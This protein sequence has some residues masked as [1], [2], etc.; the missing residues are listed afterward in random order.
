M[1]YVGLIALVS[2]MVAGVTAAQEGGAS[3]PAALDYAFYKAH[4]EPLFLVKRP[5]RMA[6]V[7]CHERG[8]GGLKLQELTNGAWAE[9]ASRKN[10]AAVSAWVAPGKP[11]TSRLLQHPLDP[12]DG[13]DPFH[14]GGKHW[15]AQDP[16]YRTL[17]SWVKGEIGPLTRTAARVIQ[18]NSAGDSAHV[19]DPATQKVIGEIYDVPIAHGV[20]GAPDGSKL[21]I[22][23]EA[24]HTLDVVDARSLSV[25]ARVPLSGRP[26]NVYTSKDGGKVY[27]GIR[28]APGALDVID[29]RTLSRAK[30]VAV[31]G[32]VH[33]VY[34]TPD[35]KYAVAGSIAGKSISIVDTATDQL[36]RSFTLSNGV[37]PIAFDTKPDGSTN[38]IFAQLSDFHGF[39]AVD[40]ATGKELARIEHP[41]IPGVHAHRDG[42][43]GAPAHGLVVTPD[44]TQLWSTSKVYGY[45]YVHALPG[46]AEVG[47]VFVGQHP[48]WLTFTPDGRY[49]YVA[50]AGDNLTFVIDTKTLKE[51]ARIPVGQVPK[52]IATAVLQVY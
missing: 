24:R 30:T 52:R 28:E 10:F 34:V 16:E 29:T 15:S 7:G 19:I 4:V 46:L 41:A 32:E 31:A 44:G 21:Y 40:F 6:C 23:D 42:L 17:A 20:V 14:A 25:V 39:V 37:R 5:G 49:A 35:G 22:S 9:D 48:E 27:V 11:A 47:R 38:R 2:L 33:N 45:A 36:V 51:V 13:G 18:T 3:R 1:R 43:Q 8:A 50:A 26:N 12:R